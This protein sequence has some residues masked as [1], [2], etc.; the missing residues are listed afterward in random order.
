MR[1]RRNW[2]T[3]A[4]MPHEVED[5]IPEYFDSNRS[6]WNKR[7]EVHFNSDFYNVKSF[8]EGK[9]SLNKIEIDEMGDVQGKTLLHLQCHF[10][11][12]TISWAKR[13]A[14]TTGLD[15]SENAIGLARKLADE[16]KEDVRFVCCNVYDAK[17]H[18]NE[19]YDIIYTSYGTIGW[20][21]DLK[22]W[23]QVIAE[24]LKPDGMFYMVDF[25]PI[26]WMFDN[27]FEFLKYSYF[28]SGEPIIEENNSYAVKDESIYGKEYGWNHSISEI[29]SALL[30]SGLSLS[31]F[32]EHSYSP[33][34]SF[35]NMVET[36]P[37]QWKIKHLQDK[38]PML[39]SLAAKK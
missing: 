33:Y 9:S 2:L 23:A 27:N 30:D 14:I 10:G 34:N 28:N 37:G 17:Q 8:K 32:N 19:K 38:I 4:Q 16:L 5:N 22:K 35:S 29:L 36:A 12:D 7:A 25:H 3:F 15:F 20:L 21:P 13:G 24:L 1:L 31:F 39:F 18:L 11:M 6:L 26:I